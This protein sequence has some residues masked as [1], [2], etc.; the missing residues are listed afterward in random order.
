MNVPC[1]GRVPCFL[2]KRGNLRDFLFDNQMV[3][4]RIE[5]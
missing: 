3:Q 5:L 1:A 2:L 4:K